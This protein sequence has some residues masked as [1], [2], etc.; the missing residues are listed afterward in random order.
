MVNWGVKAS[1]SIIALW[2]FGGRT[3]VLSFDNKRK[4]Y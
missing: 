3:A 1:F 4:V 2:L